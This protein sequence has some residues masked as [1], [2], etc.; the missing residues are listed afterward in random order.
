MIPESAQKAIVL[1]AIISICFLI[2]SNSFSVPF[3]FDDVPNITQNDAVRIESLNFK[4][5]RQALFSSRPLPILSFALNFYFGKENPFCYHFVNILIHVTTAFLLFLFIYNTLQLPALR[6]KYKDKVLFIS[7]LSVLLWCVNPL[8]SQAV[9]YIVQ[10]MAS[11]AAMFYIGS[12][13]FYLKARTSCNGRTWKGLHWFFCLMFMTMAALSKQNAVMLPLTLLL[14]EVTIIRKIPKTQIKSYAKTALAVVMVTLLLGVMAIYLSEHNFYSIFKRYEIRP[15]TPQER[16]LT[17]PRVILL[18]ISLL[19]Y[20]SP[21]RMNISHHVEISKNLFNPLSTM[22]AILLLLILITLSCYLL[23]KRPFIGFCLI[24]YFL[25]HLIESSILPLELIFEHRNYLP[26]MLFFVPFAVI[27]HKGLSIY[28]HDILIKSCIIILTAGIIGLNGVATYIRN[29]D[30]Q[31][32]KSLWYDAVVKAPKSSR[33]HLNFA[34]ELRKEGEILKAFQHAQIA[35]NLGKYNNIGEKQ[36]L[37]FLKGNC[38]LAFNALNEAIISFRKA[39]EVQAEEDAYNN[40]AIAHLRKGEL[41]KAKEALFHSI[42]IEKTAEALNNLGHILLIENEIDQAIKYLKQAIELGPTFVGAHNNLATAH[43]MNKNYLMAIDCFKKSIHINKNSNPLIPSLVNAYL[44]L[45]ESY[46]KSGNENAARSTVD[47][48][49]KHFRSDEQFS[50][51]FAFLSIFFLA[52][53]STFFQVII[54]HHPRIV[55][56]F[57]PLKVEPQVIIKITAGLQ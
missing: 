41:D 34:V 14:F 37:Y 4:E 3:Q 47:N 44:G 39:N 27:I 42:D 38:F 20:P 36:D 43:K 40:I 6:E 51:F 45:I 57:L 11:M 48:F 46:H 54:F 35:E 26:S 52:T 29:M 8:Q 21:L 7:L 18:Y 55:P 30:W 56:F 15:F 23:R 50:K 33:N 53:F 19:L 22:P 10:R 24:F 5:L 31:T 32:K 28:N 17:Q 49:L 9:T 25:N 16:L 12:M 2:Y 13:Y 1:F